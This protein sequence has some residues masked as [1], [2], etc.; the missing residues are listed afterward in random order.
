MQQQR[1]PEAQEYHKLYKLKLWCH[2]PTGL[3]W[4]CLVAALFT[5]KQC[6]WMARASETHKLVAD[7]FI[8]H[9]GDWVL[10]ADPANLR[11]LCDTCHSAG[12]QQEERLGFSTE[13]GLDGFPIDPAHPGY[14]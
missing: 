12:K 4:Q 1:S 10:F 13:V 14:G 7:H 6:G 8:P 5:C 11:C 3:R 9:R 2:K